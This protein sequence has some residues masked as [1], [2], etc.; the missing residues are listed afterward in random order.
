MGLHVFYHPQE[1]KF[2]RIPSVWPGVQPPPAGSLLS[3]FHTP[4][5]QVWRPLLG[6]HLAFPWV[7]IP[8]QYTVTYGNLMSLLLLILSFLPFTPTGL[9]RY[10]QL[11]HSEWGSTECTV[12]DF[13]FHLF[14]G[15][16]IKLML[17]NS[18]KIQG[19]GKN[20][21]KSQHFTLGPP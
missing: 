14:D 21:D 17:L 13:N 8:M 4:A 1:V 3:A 16:F 5:L 12:S 6:G 20:L 2:H 9:E 10:S 18:Y 15:F 19:S 11:C 7:T